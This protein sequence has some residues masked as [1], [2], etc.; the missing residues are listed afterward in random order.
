MRERM[1]AVVTGTGEV[2]LREERTP[3]LSDG[4]V[5]IRVRTSLIS[6]GTEMKLVQ[7]R[8]DKPDAAILDT[9][10]G[11]ANAGVILAV[12]GDAKGLSPGQRVAAMGGAALHAT[13]ACVPVNLTVPIPDDVSDEH[14][15]YVCLAATALQAVRRAGP[16][17]GEY[18]IVLGLGI[19]GN[20]CAQLASMGGARII[21]WESRA[22]RI[23]IARACGIGAA[24]DP[25]AGDAVARTQ[26]FCAP[27][28]ADFAMLAFGG[29]ATRPLE[30]VKACM[31]VSAD[32]HAMGRIVLVGGCRVEIRGG[33]ASGNLDFLAA[34]RT[35]PGYHD[36][37]YEH[38]RDYPAAFVPFTTQRNLRELMRLIAERRLAV[39]PMTT[40]RLPLAKVSE[41]ADALIQHPDQ[42]LGVILTMDP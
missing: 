5:L 14:A 30:Q 15:S 32:G 25:C 9:A 36:R 22:R 19:V 3:D 18:G 20:C 40:H 27:Y 33:A 37:A 34:S 16:Q 24:A 35:G 4:E 12:K 17:I 26:A 8:R 11:Y 31:K 13:Y 21:A 28:G 6:P 29:E 38:G 2:R 1:V 42:T 7:S 10:F 39:D 23:E 41:A